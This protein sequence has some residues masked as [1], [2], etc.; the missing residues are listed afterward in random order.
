LLPFSFKERLGTEIGDIVQ[1]EPLV[2]TVGDTEKRLAGYI[3]TSMGAQAVMPLREVQKLQ[4]NLG[5]ATGAYVTFNGPPSEETLKRLYNIPQVA[6][7]ELVSD[8]RAIMDEMMGFFWV[9]IGFMLMMGVTLGVAIIFNG[10]TINV[11]QRT[12][13][14]AVMRAIGLGDIAL[15]NMLSLENFLIGIAGVGMG[16][17]LGRWVAMMFLEASQ[18]GAEDV[19]SITFDIL[20][21]SF[22]IAAV[23]A[24]VVLL[25]SQIPA[26]LQV[27]RQNLATVTK[28]WSE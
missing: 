19:F 8:T 16:I 28:E 14:M 21:R 7:V 3:Q 22:I 9:M 5:A 13:E 24:L 12:R 11:L 17:P 2:G 26:L 20:P 27:Y 15:V 6:S 1:L 4:R 25:V 10:V 23:V 18:S